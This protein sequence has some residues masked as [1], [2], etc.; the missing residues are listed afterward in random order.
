[1]LMRACYQY[2]PF[3]NWY[4]LGKLLGSSEN[5]KGSMVALSAFVQEPR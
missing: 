4:G 5:G 2:D 3:V 1:M